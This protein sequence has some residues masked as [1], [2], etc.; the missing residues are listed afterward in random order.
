[1]IFSDP[2][3]FYAIDSSTNKLIGCRL[4]E[5][6]EYDPSIPQIDKSPIYPNER[7]NLIAGFIDDLCI[8]LH[9]ILPDSRKM[10][11]FVVVGVHPEYFRQGIGTRL[12][13]L[14]I[15]NTCNVVKR[16]DWL[17]WQPGVEPGLLLTATCT[18]TALFASFQVRSLNPVL[19]PM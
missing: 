16:V 15:G 3:S 11:K 5:I 1:M 14:S 13:Q 6:V 10:M 4:N 19:L 8:D 12:V 7:A 2:V 9:E 17:K 18:A